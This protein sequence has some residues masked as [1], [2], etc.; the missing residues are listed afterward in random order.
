[1]QIWQMISLPITPKLFLVVMNAEGA[2]GRQAL[3]IAE[4]QAFG[5]HVSEHEIP[6][7]VVLVHLG[8]HEAQAMQPLWHGREGEVV[9]PGSIGEW[10]F[11]RMIAGQE[12]ML[13]LMIPDSEAEG[14]G[15]ML[16]AFFMPTLPRGQQYGAVSHRRALLAGEAQLHSK[17]SPII[18]T[19]IRN[20]SGDA[21]S[22]EWLLIEVIFRE[23]AKKTTPHGQR[24]ASVLR[25][26]I[27]SI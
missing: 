27:W 24:R 14:S 22:G 6:G 13:L 16:D 23:E 17:L 2:A 3:H 15:Q 4:D 11:P 18:E 26:I 1:M 8:A 20:Q 25:D 7:D 10:T 5:W 9:G 12:Q 19:Y 21:G